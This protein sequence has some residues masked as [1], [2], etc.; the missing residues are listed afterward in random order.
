MFAR[1]CYR[2]RDAHHL[3][4]SEGSGACATLRTGGEEAGILI[5]DTATTHR[6]ERHGR[7][8]ASCA[9]RLSRAPR[10]LDNGHGSLTLPF[11]T[12]QLVSSRLLVASNRLAVHLREDD[13]GWGSSGRLPGRLGR[14]ASTPT[15]TKG[16]GRARRL[17]LLT[18]SGA[19]AAPA[20]VTVSPDRPGDAGSRFDVARLHQGHGQPCSRPNEDL[21]DIAPAPTATWRRSGTTPPPSSPERGAPSSST[22]TATT[23][24]AAPWP[25]AAAC[26]CRRPTC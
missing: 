5:R 26:R 21:F 9:G 24:R 2:E 4:V 3:D 13:D 6:I 8:D 20:S 16:T 19:P 12:R 10:L 7:V 25:P 23:L 15:I 1:R 22:G 18:A 14:T 17:V 11:V